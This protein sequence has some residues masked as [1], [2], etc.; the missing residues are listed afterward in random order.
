MNT[1]AAASD[2]ASG[3]AACSEEAAK[4]HAARE[5]HFRSG[6]NGSFDHRGISEL[7]HGIGVPGNAPMTS[8][9]EDG[10]LDGP[11]PDARVKV[12]VAM[13]CRQA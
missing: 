9:A 11:R 4:H 2:T 12:L 8:L 6:R 1:P 5:Q 10:K 7:T 13:G 3:S